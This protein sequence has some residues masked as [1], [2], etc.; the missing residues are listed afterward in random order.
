MKKTAV[1]A[2]LVVM[3]I[4]AGTVA[5]NPEHGNFQAHLSGAS[6]V[7]AVLTLARGQALFQ[8]SAD[9]SSVSYKLIVA[10]LHDTL[11]AHIHVG[12]EGANGPVVVF[13]Y[14]SAPPPQLIEGR[15]SGVLA[16]GTF[17]ADDLRGPLADMSLQALLDEM[18]AGNTYVNVHTVANTGGEIRGQ[19]R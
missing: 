9:G 4:I 16:E 3:L 13:L 12:A 14:P 18:V 11:Q 8:V 19:I 5:A 15:F 17:T 1:L 6:E 7:P 10:N 2:L